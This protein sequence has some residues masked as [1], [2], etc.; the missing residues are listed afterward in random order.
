VK[1][2]RDLLD[3]VLKTEKVMKAV[4]KL[5]QMIM[6]ICNIVLPKVGLEV[7]QSNI[8]VNFMIYLNK[9]HFIQRN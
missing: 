7:A 8:D 9:L 4:P 2:Y 6:E 1:D 3:S 5:E